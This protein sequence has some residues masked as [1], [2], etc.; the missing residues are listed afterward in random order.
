MGGEHDGHAL[1]PELAQPLPDD[2]AGL[3]IEA[4]GRLVEDQQ[5]GLIDETARD[6]QATLHAA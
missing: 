1:L 2:Q 5:L 4:G 3:G 6:Q